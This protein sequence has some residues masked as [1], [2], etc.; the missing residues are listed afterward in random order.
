MAK[1]SFI[2]LFLV[3]LFISCKKGKIV[4]N[5]AV[6]VRVHGDNSWGFN[7]SKG[8]VV[9]PLGKYT[10]LNPIDEHKMIHAMKGNKYG[11]IDIHQNEIVPIIYEELDLYSEGLAAAKIKGK[12]GFLDRKGKEIIVFQF[13]EVEDFNHLG[14]AKV[15]MGSKYGII[16][17]KGEPIIS[18]EFQNIILLESIKLIAVCKNNKWAFYSN[19]GKQLSDFIY[20]EVSFSKSSL[21]LVKKEGK[22]GYLDS[23]LFDRIPFG[24]YRSGTIF[25]K[26]GLA[27]VAL[28][29]GYGVINEKGI[30]IIKTEFDSI[31]YLQEQ[32]NESDSYVG[33]KNNNLTLFDEKG[34]LIIDNV[35]DYFKDYSKINNKIKGIYQVKGLNG[36]TGVVDG[37]GKLLIPLKYQEIERF[38]G[39]KKT[40]VKKNGK[41][42]LIDSNNNIVL[43]IDHEYIESYKGEQYYII[44]KTDQVGI[45][46]YN[47]KKIFDF[48]YQDISPCTYDKENRFIVKLNDRYGVIDRLGNVI[49]PFEYSEI[50]NWVEYGPGSNYHFVT[51]NQKFGLITKD[52]KVV[53]PV[54]YDKLYYKSNQTIIL[55]KNKKYGVVTIE[56]SLV[57]PFDYE[58]ICSQSFAPNKGN[59]EFYV[60]KKEHFFVINNKNEVIRNKISRK[61]KEVINLEMK[62]LK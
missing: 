53:I 28:K 7:D 25:N 46:D 14:L 4:E 44:K 60:R 1:S 51:K 3:L 41:Y 9:I 6:Y 18:F 42:G 17:E 27:I 20:D 35:K 62:F 55:V 39:S 29:N 61:E 16:N 32:Y 2:L 47:F 43:P 34:N 5:S 36:L 59:E 40:V 12:Y 37:K 19:L 33:F 21:I 38:G 23:N 11:Y 56:N 10:F 58:I 48:I 13:E 50:S 31:G 24:K 49:I 45:V 57:I 54:I 30:Q 15:K 8:N 26:N 52:G 22:V